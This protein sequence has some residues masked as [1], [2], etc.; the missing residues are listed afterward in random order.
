M[1]G[2]GLTME[3]GWGPTLLILTPADLRSLTPH[4]HF[5]SSGGFMPDRP[6]QQPVARWTP[7]ANVLWP[8]LMTPSLPKALSPRPHQ[9]LLH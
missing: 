6:W 5:A 2:P 1:G 8:C 3:G 7:A 9:H 4:E